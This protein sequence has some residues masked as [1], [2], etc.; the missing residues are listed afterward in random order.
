ML[1]PVQYPPHF[2]KK[3]RL[4]HSLCIDCFDFWEFGSVCFFV[5]SPGVSRIAPCCSLGPNFGQTPP[6]IPSTP[7]SCVIPCRNTPT[8][9]QCVF[10][11][12]L[13]ASVLTLL[14]SMLNAMCTWK[15]LW[16]SN[17]SCFFIP[18]S[19]C[20]P[21]SDLQK[22]LVGMVKSHVFL[23]LHVFTSIWC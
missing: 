1:V 21:S 4:G 16:C 22:I 7:L 15:M 10:T 14:T 20:M 8:C 18:P 19:V 13:R 2:S 5:H 6:H 23:I 12:Q 17:L 3:N 11:K 9:F